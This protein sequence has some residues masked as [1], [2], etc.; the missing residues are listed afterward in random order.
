MARLRHLRHLRDTSNALHACT[1]L[2]RPTVT[3]WKVLTTKLIIYLQKYY[4]EVFK[5]VL[6]S[7]NLTKI[8][9]VGFGQINQSGPSS[10][11]KKCHNAINLLFIHQT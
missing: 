1:H 10:L 2:P 11:D 7:A 4:W 9:Q 5:S 6:L 8:M 3:S